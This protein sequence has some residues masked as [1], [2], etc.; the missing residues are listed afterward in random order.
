MYNYQDL[1]EDG[2]INKEDAWKHWINYGK[3]EGRVCYNVYETEELNEYTN[4]DLVNI[5]NIYF[6]KKYERYGTHY[7]GWKEV[8]SNFINWFKTTNCYEYTENLFFDE[9]IEKLL[10]WGNKIINKNYLN[11]IK[12]NDYKMITFIHNPPFLYWDNSE[13]RNQLLKQMILTDNHT[14]N[15]NVFNTVYKNQ[16]TECITFLYTLS[17]NHKKYIYDN[18]PEFRTKLVSVHHPIGFDTNDEYNFNIDDFLQNRKIYNIGWWLRNFK[19]FIDFNPGLNFS[20]Y[21]LTKNDFINP[22]NNIIRKNNDL[23][24]IHVVNELSNEDYGAL[25]KNCCVFADIMDCIANNTILECIKFNTPI[26]LRR[27]KSAEEYLGTNYPLF[28]NDMNELYLLE[29]EAFLLDSIVQSH[30]YMKNMNK[31]HLYLNT[32][33]KKLNYE[34]GKLKLKEYKYKLTWICFI[35]NQSPFYVEK[36]IQCFMSQTNI[37]KLELLVFTNNLTNLDVIECI[38]KYSNIQN[39]IKI[40]NLYEQEIPIYF[41]QKIKVVLPYIDT[42]YITVLDIEMICNENF[43]QIFVNYLD[44]TLNC[45]MICCSFNIIDDELNAVLQ[46]TN[47]NSIMLFIEHLQNITIENNGIVWR[48]NMLSLMYET[49]CLE[50]NDNDF[51]LYCLEKNFNVFYFV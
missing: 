50:V 25:F 21:I 19:T 2:I 13:T 7:F 40:V 17:N 41:T 28:F 43:S 47:D 22:F 48:T 37:N 23:S 39:N 44:S 1:V 51:I 34:I 14:F 16:C 35:L 6:K 10:I 30:Y 36:F 38:N 3:K 24:N 49:N 8:I 31:T 46:N 27:T 12:L 42:D 15:E 29:E 5:N 32:F 4:F 9:W 20:K 18:Y 11:Q 26:I 33:N 45:D